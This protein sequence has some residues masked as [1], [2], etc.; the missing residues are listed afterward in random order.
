MH[1]HGTGYHLELQINTAK[2]ALIWVRIHGDAFSD[3][4][5]NVKKIR[6][7]LM[8]IDKYKINEASL[9]KSM[10]TVSKDNTQLKGFTHV[11]SHIIRNHA[12]NLYLLTSM[13]DTSELSKPNA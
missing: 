2:G 5:E 6:G 3:E 11:L 9:H 4:Y 8:N 1:K 7:V 12:S 13:I 10:G